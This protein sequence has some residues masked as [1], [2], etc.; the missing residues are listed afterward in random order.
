MT[1]PNTKSVDWL[2]D[3]LTQDMDVL[4][5]DCRACED[6][7]ASH[8]EGAINVVIPSLMLKRLKKGNCSINTLI[9]SDVGKE[10]FNR[11]CKEDFVILYDEAS[12][13]TGCTSQTINLL[14]KKL[15]EDGCRAFYLQGGFN[16]FHTEYPELCESTLESSADSSRGDLPPIFGLGGL[17]ISSDLCSSSDSSSSSEGSD[18]CSD[19]SDSDSPPLDAYPVQILPYLYLGTAKDAANL[20]SLRKYGITHILNVT[21]NLP[22]KFEGSETFTY[23]QIPISDHWSQNLSQFFPDAISFI[24]EARQ[25]KTA[26]LV[27]CLAGVSRSVTV[28]VAYLMQKLNLS[29]NDAYDYVKQR[30]SNI[31]PNFNFMGQLLDFERMLEHSHHC[32]NCQ[33]DNVPKMQFTATPTITPLHS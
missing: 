25:K 33:C 27:H 10:R 16:Q 6:Y 7:A 3:H 32:T 20:D 31:S 23:K 2:Y 8:I 5:L 15:Q 19:S 21:P 22:N 12:T 17:R 11:R 26:V 24:E 1:E 13:D 29:L 28:T 30:K 9:L 4:Q 14:M 18:I